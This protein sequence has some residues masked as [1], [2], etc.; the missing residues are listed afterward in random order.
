MT[1]LEQVITE[2]IRTL[3]EARYAWR[4]NRWADYP[5]ERNAQYQELRTLVGLM[6]K[7]RDI[8]R[9]TPDLTTIALQ[10]PAEVRARSAWADAAPGELTEAWGR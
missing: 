9:G 6:R 2:R 8:S 7:A 1:P 4:R 5:P 3:W 10:W